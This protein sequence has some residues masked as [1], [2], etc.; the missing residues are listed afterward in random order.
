MRLGTANGTADQRWGVAYFEHFALFQPEWGRRPY[1]REKSAEIVFAVD[2]SLVNVGLRLEATIGT[3]TLQHSFSPVGP[4]CRR[5][6]SLATIPASISV[7]VNVT[8]TIVATGERIVHPRLFSRA[9]APEVAT[10]PQQHTDTANGTT[11]AAV[12]PPIPTTRVKQPTMLPIVWQVDHT[13]RSLRAD[14]VPWIANG[15]FSGGYD[16]ESAGIPPRLAFPFESSGQTAEAWEKTQV[17][18]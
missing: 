16:H 17:H 8:L 15:W 3:F 11:S 7:L 4:W 13:I 9:P 1:I 5:T 6:F 14:G 12:S 18:T 2:T 10:S